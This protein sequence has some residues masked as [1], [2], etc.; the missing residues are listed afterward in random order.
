MPPPS[1]FNACAQ[2]CTPCSAAQSNTGGRGA[3]DDDDRRGALDV[4]LPWESQAPK[5]RRVTRAVKAADADVQAAFRDPALQLPEIKHV[6]DLFEHPGYKSHATGAAERAVDGHWAIPHGPGGD[7]AEQRLRICKRFV[8]AFLGDG[9]ATTAK[10]D[11]LALQLFKDPA[12]LTLLRACVPPGWLQRSAH[13]PPPP[14]P[15]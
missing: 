12:L 14:P 9:R 13:Q 4:K 10:I 6:R 3:L 5:S 15:R 7:D 2:T 11:E 1:F 8:Q